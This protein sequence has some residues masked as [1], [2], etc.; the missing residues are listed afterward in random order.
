MDSDTRLDICSVCIVT[1][2]DGDTCPFCE[3][4]ADLFNEPDE[5]VLYG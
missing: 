3:V 4:G 5:E 1:L 2:T